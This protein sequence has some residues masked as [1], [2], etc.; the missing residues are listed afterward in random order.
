[1]LIMET[2]Q[3]FQKSLSIV[4]EDGEDQL[5]NNIFHT[6][7]TCHEKVCNVIIDSGIFENVVATEMVKK[8]KL[9]TEQYPQPYKLSQLKKGNEIEYDRRVVH[10]G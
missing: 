1:M 5:R 8:L 7:C 4:C 2:L 3:L 9:K 6:R 10:D